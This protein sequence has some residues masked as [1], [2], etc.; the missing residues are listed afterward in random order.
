MVRFFY[1][2]LVDTEN[3]IHCAFVMRKSC[4]AS[5]KYVS[6][7]RLEVNVRCYL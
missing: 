2:R 3:K 5:L 7:P 4:V 6:S 1:L